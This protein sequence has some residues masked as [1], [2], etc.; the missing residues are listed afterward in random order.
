MGKTREQILEWESRWTVAAGVAA[1]VALGLVVA[2]IFLVSQA[3]GNSADQSTTLRNIDQHQTAQ[4]ISNILQGI[5]VALL[6]FPLYFLFRA[7]RARG[8]TVRGQ[9][10]GLVVAGPLL[11]AVVA[12]L[13]GVSSLDAA[14]DFVASGV[15]GSGDRANDLA[16]DALRDA[17]LRPLINGLG[18]GGVLAFIFGMVYT[19]LQAM[20]VGLLSR[21][22]GTLGMALGAA[23]LLP[24]LP[25]F[26]MLW[27]GYLGVLFLGRAPAGSPPAWAAGEAIPW[28]TPGEKAAAELQ[29]PDDNPSDP[30]LPEPPANGNGGPGP[31]PGEPR[32]KRKQRD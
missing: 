17:S 27:F 12:I 25:P 8:A 24:A 15:R 4:M 22:W 7:T 30:D 28:P 31:G 5:G 10:V 18:L 16:S 21:F 6:T 11:L 32:R 2:S 3:V 20:R 13:S 19:S 9:L 1:L 26:Y 14:N 23:S 29:P